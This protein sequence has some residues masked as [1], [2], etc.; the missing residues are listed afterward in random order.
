MQLKSNSR[1]KGIAGRGFRAQEFEASELLIHA[2]KVA[3]GEETG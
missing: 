3:G 1:W 2:C